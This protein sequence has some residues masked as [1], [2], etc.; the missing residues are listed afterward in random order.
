MPDLAELYADA[1]EANADAKRVLEAQVELALEAMDPL[2]EERTE[3]HCLIEGLQKRFKAVAF[4]AIEPSKG[5]IGIE[6][7]GAAS[8]EEC[9]QIEDWASMAKLSLFHIHC[10]VK[11]RFSGREGPTSYTTEYRF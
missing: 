11:M 5:E 9:D 7:F 6:A 8:Q 1:E 3:A 10:A 2:P 4:R